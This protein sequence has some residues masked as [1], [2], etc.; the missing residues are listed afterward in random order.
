MNKISKILRISMILLAAAVA[1]SVVSNLTI[2]VQENHI[3][4][5]VVQDRKIYSEA[6]MLRKNISQ[7]ALIQEA[8]PVMPGAVK[9]SFESV[10]STLEYFAVVRPGSGAEIEAIMKNAVRLK[11][12]ALSGKMSEGSWRVFGQVDEFVGSAIKSVS[13]KSY[14]LPEWVFL[15]SFFGRLIWAAF[16]A[17]FA[18][19]VFYGVSGLY[20]EGFFRKLIKEN[21]VV[22]GLTRFIN[23]II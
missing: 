18:G 9:E 11:D 20:K 19:F 12:N 6:I 5:L 16:F 23:I 1:F 7:L 3:T 10:K 14:K 17:A 22:S 13:G 8:G 4:A 2:T 21:R 15:I